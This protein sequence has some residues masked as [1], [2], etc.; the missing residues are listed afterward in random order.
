MIPASATITV[1]YQ[2][3]IGGKVRCIFGGWNRRVISC[4]H[5]YYCQY[6]VC[7][8]VS[9]WVC[10]CVL[11]DTS[12]KKCVVN[13]DIFCITGFN[14]SIHRACMRL[15][16]WNF[17][18]ITNNVVTIA[19]FQ[20]RHIRLHF[21]FSPYTAMV[22]PHGRY[23][24]CQFRALVQVLDYFCCYLPHRGWR[25]RAALSGAAL[26]SRHSVRGHLT[27]TQHLKHNTFQH[28][29][30]GH[31]TWKYLPLSTYFPVKCE[32]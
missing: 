18:L 21:P 13:I 9:T 4:Y 11:M 6:V 23:L 32:K 3:E 28:K 14:I 30:Q 17:V 22:H 5:G 2:K 25:E 7:V 16:V 27:S 31:K 15:F 8:C 26:R 19:L 24:F 12:R 29:P 1:H 20:C 10:V